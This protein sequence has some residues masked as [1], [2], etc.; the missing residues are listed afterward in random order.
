[1][2]ARAEEMLQVLFETLS[3]GVAEDVHR[4]LAAIREALSAEIAELRGNTSATQRECSRMGRELVRT[5]ATLEGMQTSLSG[6]A[7]T[8]D[9]LESSLRAEREAAAAREAKLRQEG[10]STMLGDVLAT[11][12][13]LEAGIEEAR[14]LAEA[15]SEVGRR[16]GDPTVRRWWRALGEATGAKRP[17]PEIPSS[18]LESW[19]RGLELTYRRLR[20][21]LER[22][23]IVAVEATG[24][25]FDPHLH[26]AVAVAPCPPEQDGIVLREELR[27]YRTDH[28]VIRLAQVVVGK[29]APPTTKSRRARRAVPES[30]TG[31][32]NDQSTEQ[33][34]ITE[35]SNDQ[36]TEQEQQVNE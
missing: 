23:G 27:G 19:L 6:F 36:R 13:G 11:L 12:D 1:M 17:L 2:G 15:L 5:G 8:L 4:D 33:H 30:A 3:Q 22:Q 20:D 26:E 21:A 35:D 7:G 28:R 24:K 9:R 18:D 10:W 25:P 16:L 31:E 14:G 32:S 29:A 34:P